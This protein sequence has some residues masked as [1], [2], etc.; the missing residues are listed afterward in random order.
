MTIHRLT[1]NNQKFQVEKEKDIDTTTDMLLHDLAPFGDTAPGNDGATRQK[2]REIVSN[3]AELG[4]EIAR[5]PFEIRPI[6][7]LK[8][9]GPFVEDMMTDVDPDE[10][11]TISRKTTIILSHPWVKVTYDE[12][13]NGVLPSTY[14]SK[15][16]V[17]CIC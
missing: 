1:K 12:M 2:L 3:V 15:A 11:E 17:S 7:D 5:L 13:G 4:L 9:G 14:L 8:P 16:R 6:E 10:E